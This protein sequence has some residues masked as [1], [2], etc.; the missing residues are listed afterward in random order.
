MTSLIKHFLLLTSLFFSFTNLQAQLNIKVG[1]GLSYVNPDVSHRITDQY[2]T[3]QAED[4]TQS[5]K[6]W[7][8]LHGM[9]AGLRYRVRD[10]GLEAT[11]TNKYSTIRSAGE[12]ATG[13]D[14]SRDLFFR[15]GS[16][17][18]GLETYITEE[19][20]VG[21]SFDVENYRI[22]TDVASVDNRFTILSQWAYGSHFNMS[23]NLSGSD[24][25]TLSIKPFVHIP[26]S[27]V[28]LSKL[29]VEVN[30]VDPETVNTNDYNERFINFGIQFIFYNG[31]W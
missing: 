5:F 13:T 10:I 29:Q 19:I 2:N 21:V 16:Y 27:S 18:I 15:I 23:F 4:L 7:H 24:L 25:L 11:W 14:I 30:N 6:E 9:T 22:R 8:F 28:D 17:G 26:W 12:D 1:Y 20:G 3:E 31:Q